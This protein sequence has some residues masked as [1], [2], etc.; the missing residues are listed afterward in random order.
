MMTNMIFSKVRRATGAMLAS[1]PL[2]L[3]AFPN[4]A[5]ALM[6]KIDPAQSQVHYSSK[7]S[8]CFPDASGEIICPPPTTEIYGIS[9]QI[10]LEVIP[11]FLSLADPDPYRFL[12]SLTPVGIAS[13]ALATGLQLGTVLAQLNDDDTFTALSDSGC[14]IPPGFIASCVILANGETT[15][16]SGV[17]DGQTLTWRG[18]QTSFFA[19]HEYTIMASV[20]SVPEPGTLLLTLP[21]LIGLFGRKMPRPG[22]RTPCAA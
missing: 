14:S 17:W 1:L 21:A 4:P 18:L 13:D 19:D 8:F 20:A 15:A 5:A 22:R 7:L 3:A 6:L 2:L 11:Q 16:A 10:E 12:L 9:G